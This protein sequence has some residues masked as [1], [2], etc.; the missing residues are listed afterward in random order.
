MAKNETV[1]NAE[2]V[3]LQRMVA[4]SMDLLTINWF[5]LKIKASSS[6]Y[7]YQVFIMEKVSNH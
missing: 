4:F 5:I 7:N 3:S 6:F 2:Q 1:T